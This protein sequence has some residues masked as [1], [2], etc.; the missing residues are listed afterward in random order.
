[1]TIIISIFLLIEYKEDVSSVINNKKVYALFYIGYIFNAP[2]FAKH[3]FE[4]IE[5]KTD[6]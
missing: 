6:I 3:L 2:K 4:R 5:K 1:M